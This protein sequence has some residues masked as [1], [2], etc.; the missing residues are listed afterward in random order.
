MGFGLSYYLLQAVAGHGRPH[1]V[2]APAEILAAF[3]S[4]CPLQYSYEYMHSK[5][6]SH[7]SSDWPV[8]CPDGYYDGGEGILAF[9]LSLISDSFLIEALSSSLSGP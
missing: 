6:A 4:S 1:A 2:P 7:V 9:S 8:V 5:K 3:M